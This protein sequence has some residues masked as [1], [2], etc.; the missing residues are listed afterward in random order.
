MFLFKK[1]LFSKVLSPL[2]FNGHTVNLLKRL[3]G[4]NIF[5]RIQMRVL[6]EKHQIKLAKIEGII[7]KRVLLEGEPYW[8]F[9]GIWYEECF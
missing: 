8:K 1:I 7:R 9:Y 2:Y 5:Y 3:A 6:L 4:I